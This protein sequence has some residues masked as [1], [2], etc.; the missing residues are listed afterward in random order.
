MD[1]T[2]A[3]VAGMTALPATIAAVIAATRVKGVKEDTHSTK[4]NT[5]TV[6]DHVLPNGGRSL[7]DRVTRL[8]TSVNKLA[9]AF[10]EHSRKTQ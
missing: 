6:K 1:V 10:T 2:S 5:Q 4:E 8:E 9:T 7:S 3:I